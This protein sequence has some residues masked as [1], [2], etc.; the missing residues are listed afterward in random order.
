MIKLQKDLI[1]YQQIIK[2][3][4]TMSMLNKFMIF[5]ILFLFGLNGQAQV[6]DLY[7]DLYESWPNYK[8]EG[9]E[10]RRFKHDHIKSSLKELSENELFKIREVGKSIE[11]RELYLVSA[12]S[13]NVD[14]FLWSQMHGDESTATMA[15]FDIFNF[16]K[17]D[18]FNAKKKNLLSKV[19]IHVMPMMNPD[20]AERFQRRNALGVDLNRDALRLQNPESKTLKRLRDSLDADFGFNLHDQS[21]YYNASRTSKPATISFLAPAYNYEKDINEVRGNAM[22]LIVD[23][24]EI[25]QHYVPGQVGRYNDDFEPRA[26]G[27]N[28]QKWGTSTVLIE[29][30]GYPNDPEKQEIRRLNFTIILAS[31][32]SI[33]NGDYKDNSLEDYDQIPENDRKLFDLKIIGANYELNGEDYI[34]DIGLNNNEVDTGSDFYYR[35]EI[36]DLGDLSTSYGYENLEAEGYRILKPKVSERTFN[37]LA[38]IDVRQLLK[39]GI[40]YVR[41]KTIPKMPVSQFPLNIVS[42]DFKVS[43]DLQSTFFLEKDS[44]IKYAVINGFLIDL[45]SEDISIPNSV[46]LK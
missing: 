30:G 6:P 23:L 34:I 26:F 18:D 21:K 45:D 20:G 41:M 7:K 5:G 4:F 24:N 31:L 12:G 8:A 28:I 32:F 9:F 35:S 44:V 10:I 1:C 40:G 3:P 37:E 46:I 42:E 36:A 19:K 22:K 17:S 29:S 11:G 14:V 43:E 13:G 27:D 2:L 39:Q 25:L 38:N 33:A 15:L 16:L